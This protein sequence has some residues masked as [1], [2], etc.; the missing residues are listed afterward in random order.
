MDGRETLF[1]F[2]GKGVESL[3]CS[4]CS[5]CPWIVYDHGRVQG[6]RNVK[7]LE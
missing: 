4:P 3:H 6:A 2:D 7:L 5:V 1:G